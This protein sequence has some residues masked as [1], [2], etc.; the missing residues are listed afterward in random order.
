MSKVLFRPNEIDLDRIGMEKSGEGDY[1][2]QEALSQAGDEDQIDLDEAQDL[3]KALADSE[4]DSAVQTGELDEGSVELYE[5]DTNGVDAVDYSAFYGHQQQPFSKE[6]EGDPAAPLSPPMPVL[7]SAPPTTT[8]VTTS[9][10]Q[11]PPSRDTTPTRA[12]KNVPGLGFRLYDREGYPE[13]LNPKLLTKIRWEARDSKGEEELEQLSGKANSKSVRSSAISVSDSDTG[14]DQ[15]SA[16]D[17]IFDVGPIVSERSEHEK[18][19]REGNTVKVVEF[20]DHNAPAHGLPDHS[21]RLNPSSPP[22]KFVRSDKTVSP[23]KHLGPQQLKASSEAQDA[24]SIATNSS[25]PAVE[26]DRGEEND[27]LREADGEQALENNSPLQPSSPLRSSRGGSPGISVRHDE[28]ATAMDEAKITLD[29]GSEPDFD[30]LVSMAEEEGDV[31]DVRAE[32]ATVQSDERQ[33]AEPEGPVYSPD[34][35]RSPTPADEV[36]LGPDGFPLPSA[37]E[38]EAMDEE[39]EADLEHMEGDQDEFVSFLSR[40]KGRGLHEVRREVEDEVNKLRSEHANT[41]RNEGDVT[42]QMAKEIQLML[43][44]FGLPYITAPMEAEAQ[45]AELVA[46]GLADGIIT[47]DSDVFLFGGTFIYKNMFNNK[48]YVECYKLSDLQHDLGMDRTK[49]V[50]LAYL[51]GSDYTDG[52]EGVGPV[53]AMEILSNFDGDDALVKFR[54]WWM[55]VQMGQD[56][57]RDTCNTTLKRIKRT[58]RNKV[59]VNDSWPDVHVLNAYYEPTVDSSDESFQWGL[60][61][62]DS[63]RSFFFEYLRWDREKTDHYLIPA[64]EEQNRRN[65]RTQGTLDTTNFFDL[66]AGQSAYAGRARPGYNSSRLQQVI[67]NFRASKRA[68]DRKQA[69]GGDAQEPVSI[70]EDEDGASGEDESGTIPEQQ[71]GKEMGKRSRPIVSREGAPTVGEGT[72]EEEREETQEHSTGKRGKGR[73]RG[74]GRGVPQRGRKTGTSGRG[75]KRVERDGSGSSEEAAVPHVDDEE[76]RPRA[77]KPK[78]RKTGPADGAPGTRLTQARSMNLDHVNSL[79]PSRAPGMRPRMSASTSREDVGAAAVT[80]SED[81]SSALSEEE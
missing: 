26:E 58:L 23:Q 65:R 39:D 80:I 63:L 1:D 30:N 32:A 57:P 52:L 24:I 60:P 73:G 33:E 25:E 4:K 49:L 2:L 48:K 7:N 41:R 15:R 56:T 19:D 66:S 53:L 59:H 14:D 81:E 64:I 8:R 40:A 61:D 54:E 62:L 51:L 67:T 44:L 72:Q 16:K 69:R 42:Q 12:I 74:R 20:E 9:R 46:I 11:T 45:C 17:I 21:S 47:D 6:T 75:R 10:P 68:A 77:A 38:L 3:A 34:W 29:D 13:R 76:W 70:S 28:Q 22:S 35:S 5:V 18:Q 36:V 71:L 55:K 43:R 78:K 27:S 79:P 37:A 50:Q 31:P